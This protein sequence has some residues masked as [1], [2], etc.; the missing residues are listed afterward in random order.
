MLGLAAPRPSFQGGIGFRPGGVLLQ[1]APVS[2]RALAIALQTCTKYTLTEN[3]YI[4]DKGLFLHR[5]SSNIHKY[6]QT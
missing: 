5:Q 1:V 2:L 3:S 4:H 6:M